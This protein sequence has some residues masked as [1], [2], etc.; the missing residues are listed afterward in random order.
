MRISD[1]SSDVCS[2][3]LQQAGED[4][5]ERMQAAEEGDDDGGEAV[6][7]RDRRDELP[8][9]PG[10]LEEAGEAGEPAAQQQAKPHHARRT[11]AG[12]ARRS[13]RLAEDAQLTAED[14]EATQHPAGNRH[15]QGAPGGEM[16][17]RDLHTERQP[18][19]LAENYPQRG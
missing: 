19:G 6:A 13:R 1:W 10:D 16:H 5:A 4:D 9:R 2:S 11:E 7:G 14:G 17:S 18:G 8:D 3:D 15:P 12:E